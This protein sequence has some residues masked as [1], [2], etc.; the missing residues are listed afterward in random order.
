MSTLMSSL[1]SENTAADLQLAAMSDAVLLCDFSRYPSRVTSQLNSA[2]AWEISP[3][4][5]SAMTCEMSLITS[6]LSK[7]ARYHDDCAKRKSP[8]RI[9]TRV[10]YSV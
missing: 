8:A 3:S 5:K 7:F 4:A 2:P 1:T 10:P 9:A 6:R